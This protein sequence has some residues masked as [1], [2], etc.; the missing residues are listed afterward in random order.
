MK[1][2]FK[3]HVF[4]GLLSIALGLAV[5]FVLTPMYSRAIEKKD[6][7]VRLKRTV[8]AGNKIEDKDLELIE[9]GVYNLSDNIIRSKEK[10][11]GKYAKSALYAGM[12]PVE[13]A[14]SET[15]LQT[16]LYLNRIP[17]DK[18]AVSVTVQNYAAGLSSK[19]LQGD[20]VS[21]VIK[22]QSA[23]GGIICEIPDTLMYMEVLSATQESGSDKSQLSDR[24]DEK[25]ASNNRL[26][27]VTL[28]A[29]KHQVTE[30]TSYEG[31]AVI[32]IAL[33]N[34]SDETMKL[35]LLSIQEEYFRELE[36]AEY[37]NTE[38]EEEQPDTNEGASLPKDTETEHKEE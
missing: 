3:S 21:L 7:V 13:E 33:K 16:D 37:A 14:L 29:N 25:N 8:P 20:I 35:K 23:D 28:L 17:E 24:K 5:S 11:S 36:A 19:L 26:A 15:P 22:R 31:D 2:M 38:E 9:I 32:H 1:R 27:T 6:K 12:Y 34:R 10:V 4:I 30:L 18:Y